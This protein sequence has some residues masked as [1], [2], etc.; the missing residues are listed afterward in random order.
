MEKYE[1]FYANEINQKE[2]RQMITQKDM[3][4]EQKC[5]GKSMEN[6]QYKDRKTRTMMIKRKLIKSTQYK[7]RKNHGT[8]ND[9]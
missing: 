3:A 9:R 7:K 2:V 4:I 5:E 6:Q 8:Y 1:E